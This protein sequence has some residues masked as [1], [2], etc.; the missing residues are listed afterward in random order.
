MV[1]TS[2]KRGFTLIELLVVIAIIAILAAILFPV[3]AQAR[4]KARQTACMSNQRQI[5]LAIMMDA[6]DSEEYLTTTAKWTGVVNN[7][8]I[9]MCKDTSNSVAFVYNVALSGKALGAFS[10]PTEVM[11]TADGYHTISATT[12]NAWADGLVSWF[13]AD[14]GVTVDP[15]NKV[16]RWEPRYGIYTDGAPEITSG[17]YSDTDIVFRHNKST[18]MSFLDGHVELRKGLPSDGGGSLDAIETPDPITADANDVISA[19]ANAPTFMSSGI[20]GQPAVSFMTSDNGG[21][22]NFLKLNGTLGSGTALDFSTNDFTIIMI[23]DMTADPFSTMFA[24]P[25]MVVRSGAMNIKSG[26]LVLQADFP[27]APAGPSF[28]AVTLSKSSTGWYVSAAYNSG[29]FT[30]SATPLTSRGA[31]DATNALFL[32][33]DLCTFTDPDTR[34]ATLAAP[35]TMKVSEILFFNRALSQVEVNDATNSVFSRLK[36]NYGL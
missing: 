10:S 6:Q 33:N 35:A 21:L 17:C 30:T 15:N 4:E 1:V 27:A 8:K 32:G 9:L 20:N 12:N 22:G 3:F 19:A 18:I 11:M 13:S 26:S 36:G 31:A 5:A 14:K 24:I 34:T 7:R 2:F 29:T 28:S 25:G 16:L 23:R